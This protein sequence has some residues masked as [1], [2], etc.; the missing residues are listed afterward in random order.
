[1]H[2]DDIISKG[3]TSL[4]YAFQS[5]C[6]I[7]KKGFYTKIP[8]RNIDTIGQFTGFKDIDG[9][10]I[11]EG[12]IIQREEKPKQTYKI[13]MIDGVWC[14]VFGYDYQSLNWLLLYYSIKV[15]GNIHDNP[16]LLEGRKDKIND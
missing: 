1:M 10:E 6:I 8:F 3:S 15:I 4:N 2:E 9:K 12:D 5:K 13:E 11:Y 14:G 7:D 16:E